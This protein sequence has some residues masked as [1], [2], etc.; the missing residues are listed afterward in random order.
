MQ[1]VPSVQAPPITSRQANPLQQASAVEQGWPAEAQ[2]A[3]RHVPVPLAVNT[4][5][6]PEQQSE[7]AVQAPSWGWHAVGTLQV[8]PMHRAEQQVPEESHGAPLGLQAPAP[9]SAACP[10]S[11]GAGLPASPPVPVPP[12]TRD[13]LWQTYVSSALGRQ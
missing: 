1:A 11:D 13:G 7:E 9:P 10:P 8:P 4:Q 12:S 6:S 3:G 2:L 5:E